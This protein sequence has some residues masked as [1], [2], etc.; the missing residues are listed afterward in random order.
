MIHACPAREW[1]V[2]DFLVPSLIDQGIS[3]NEI[4]VWVDRDGRGNLSGY[5]SKIVGNIQTPSS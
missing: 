5:S 4:S 2:T 1:Y 3:E